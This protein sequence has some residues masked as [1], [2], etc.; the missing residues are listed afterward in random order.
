MISCKALPSISTS[1]DLSNL[2]PIHGL[3]EIRIPLCADGCIVEDSVRSTYLAHNILSF[4]LIY[5]FQSM[6]NN[7]F[8]FVFI[9]QVLPIF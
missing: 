7:F 8:I 2:R 9:T 4:G 5:L 6:S 3:G 1:Y